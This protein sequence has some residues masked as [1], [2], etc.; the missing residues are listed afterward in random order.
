MKKVGAVIA[1]AV[2]LVVVGFIGLV[3]YLR[4]FSPVGE[5]F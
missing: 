4:F 1:L 2:V 5:F 3:V